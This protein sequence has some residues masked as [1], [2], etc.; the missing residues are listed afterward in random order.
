MSR[1][2]EIRE[3][4][5][6][7]QRD[8]PV[9]HCNRCATE[10]VIGETWGAGN[11]RVSN[12]MCNSCEKKIS[13]YNRLKRLARNV[14]KIVWKQY[15]TAKDGYVYIIS[16]PTWSGWYKIGMALDAEDRLNSY[17]TS[18]PFRDYVLEY[19]K[20]FKDRK[21]AEAMAHHNIG[22]I[23]DK[24]ANEWFQVPKHEAINVIEG[25]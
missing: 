24:R 15:D 3:D 7:F 1:L 14:S 23:S 18:S 19:S 21:K 22:R 13:R 25:I 9:K 20:Y 4:V 16:N 10:L 5:P 2:L 17:Q 6:T 12:Y 8:L 11:A